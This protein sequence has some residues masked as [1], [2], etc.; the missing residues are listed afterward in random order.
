MLAGTRFY[1]LK[2][3]RHFGEDLHHVVGQVAASHPAAQRLVLVLVLVE[4]RLFLVLVFVL[5]LGL[6]LVVTEAKQMKNKKEC[7]DPF[8]DEEL[9]G[10]D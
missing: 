4:Q 5:V 3:K 10:Q 7:E 8:K 6:G 9:P 1:F 2:I